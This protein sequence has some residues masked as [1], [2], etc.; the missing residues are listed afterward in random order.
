MTLP[1]TGPTCMALVV[2]VA[3][4][5]HQTIVSNAKKINLVTISK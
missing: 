4:V 1:R 3:V 2:T 5:D